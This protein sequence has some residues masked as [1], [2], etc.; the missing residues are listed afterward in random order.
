MKII[1]LG[2]GGKVG[3][4][5]VDE[6]L[7]RDYQV[8]AFTHNPA[9]FGERKGLTCK[10]GDVHDV[11]AVAKAVQGCGAAISALG[12]WGT[13]D[14]DILSAGMQSLIPAMKEQGIKR[15]ISLTGSDA[16]ATGDELSLLHRLSR[17]LLMM[18]SRKVLTDGEN[19]IKLLEDSGLDWTVIRSPRM[20][21]RGKAYALSNKRP[22]PWTSVGRP[23]V[24]NCLVDQ[25]DDRQHLHQAPFIV[26]A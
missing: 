21:K 22:L 1:I 8:I 7:Q 25:L 20:A 4:L 16:R 13:P 11:R 12:S 17:N 9:K 24:A 5:V 2:A 18:V 14:K 26:R 3:R 19:H 6:A 10:Q 23:A 15:I